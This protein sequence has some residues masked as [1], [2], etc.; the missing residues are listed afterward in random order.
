MSTRRPESCGSPN[1]HRSHHWGQNSACPGVVDPQRRNESCEYTYPHVPHIRTFTGD[2]RC[3][4]VAVAPGMRA[5]PAKSRQQAL[6]YL[7]SA[8]ASI[9][10]LVNVW[11]ASATEL[12]FTGEEHRPKRVDEMP[13]NDPRDWSRLAAEA[14]K[15]AQHFAR[16]AKWADGNARAVV[17]HQQAR[18]EEDPERDAAREVAQRLVPDGKGGERWQDMGE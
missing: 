2:L 8:R 11:N 5:M 7:R 16:I 18:L 14:A 3:P 9:G 13:E 12:S 4:G 6:D 15:L 17:A 1:P 10:V